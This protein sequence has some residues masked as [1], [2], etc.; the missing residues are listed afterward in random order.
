MLPP[1][2]LNAYFARRPATP[3]S[4]VAAGSDS[5]APLASSGGSSI[6]SA[7]LP[8]ATAK[9][10]GKRADIGSSSSNS[11][12]AATAPA[13]PAAPGSP[14]KKPK[15][16]TPSAALTPQQQLTFAYVKRRWLDVK[17]SFLPSGV[18]RTNWQKGTGTRKA[19][20][21]AL[22]Q[23]RSDAERLGLAPSSIVALVDNATRRRQDGAQKAEQALDEMRRIGGLL[24]AADAANGL[25][26]EGVVRLELAEALGA[27]WV[28]LVGG[29]EAAGGL[30]AACVAYL[31]LLANERWEGGLRAAALGGEYQPTAARPATLDALDEAAA[32]GDLL[33]L[34]PFLLLSNRRCGAPSAKLL[35]AAMQTCVGNRPAAL[36]A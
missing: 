22:K 8:V 21:N 31:E 26:T 16:G 13:Q 35:Y 20:E 9:I 18:A 30:V 15:S 27:D 5:A 23:L 36:E 14:S 28:A 17:E 12:T 10:T 7:A 25:S 3:A 2:T 24:T 4:P 32:A 6:V 11:S 19:N 34:L 29:E 1:N 33:R